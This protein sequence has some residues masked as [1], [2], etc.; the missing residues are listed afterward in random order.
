M[1]TAIS[2]HGYFGRN[3]DLEYG[4]GEQ[5]VITP[6]NH[7]LYFRKTERMDSH[8]AYLGMAAL[9][10][11]VALYFDGINEHGLCIAA[12]DF[13]DNAYY[14]APTECDYSIAPFELIP[15]ILSQC[16]TVTD[17]Y[18]LMHKT[19]IVDIQY[20]ESFPQA[21]LHWMVS[22]NAHSLVIE[23]MKS[24]LMLYENTIA[25]LC[26]NPPFP[27]QMMH[28]SNF[29]YL[30]SGEQPNNFF[31]L[32]LKPYCGGMGALGLP[33][34]YS[35]PSR[36][37][38]ATFVKNHAYCKPHKID[39]ITQFFHIMDSVSMPRGA[40]RVR[41]G[42]Y[43]ITRYTSCCDMQQCVYYF[44]TYENRRIRAVKLHCEKLDD[45]KLE[46]FPLYD[47]Q[48]ILCINEAGLDKR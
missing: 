25:V 2:H 7:P 9:D 24:G 29:Q 14:P 15:W 12:L 18:N 46:C 8:Y 37:V 34:D 27:Y 45:N 4:Y 38:R 16:K 31:G 26:N 33:G 22:D 21:P 1:C 20:G 11:G 5:I 35:S 42:Q 3:L 44:T 47:T 10:H 36:F 19:K 43:E 32:D 23:P 6:R 40:I 30:S 41:G 28:L 48:D 17:V 39:E 13:P